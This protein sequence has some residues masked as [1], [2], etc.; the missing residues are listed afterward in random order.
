MSKTAFPAPTTSVEVFDPEFKFVKEVPA[1]LVV[2]LPPTR[3][4]ITRLVFCRN[5]KCGEPMSCS[6]GDGCKFVHADVD[7]ESLEAHPIHVKYAW[8]HEDL[9]TYKR[10]PAG[11]VLRV[12]A[13]NNRPPVEEIPTERIL[14]TQG[15]LNHAESAGPLSH[16]AH[17]YF[18][19]M[20]NRGEQC[21]FVHAV[22]VDENVVGDFKRAPARTSAAAVHPGVVPPARSQRK[23]QML[24]ERET[25]K[26]AMLS[27]PK[28]GD[29]E[30]TFD[31]DTFSKPVMGDNFAPLQLHRVAELPRYRRN[32]YSLR[33]VTVRV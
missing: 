6:M 4:N 7:P 28:H 13:P 5:Y 27:L 32:P 8:R 1:A 2:H 14:V 31:F 12:T 9:C 29:F 25:E 33:E 3:L 23:G 22:Y 16:C 21:N 10:L 19:R 24:N 17:Y 15:S 30:T 20:C 26:L 18:N 11:S